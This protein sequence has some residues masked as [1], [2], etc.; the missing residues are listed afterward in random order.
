MEKREYLTASQ[1]ASYLGISRQSLS[2][3]AKRGD[4]GT[5]V[6]SIGSRGGWVYV[7]THAELDTWYARERHKGGRPKSLAGPQV[8]A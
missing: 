5:R 8:A 4:I 2:T 7:F 6:E 3:A 1:A